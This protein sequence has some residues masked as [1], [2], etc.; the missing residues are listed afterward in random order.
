MR[1]LFA[2]AL[3]SLFA[4]H[5]SECDKSVKRLT[6]L[7]AQYDAL[8]GKPKYNADADMKIARIAL[9]IAVEKRNVNSCD[10]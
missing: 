4:C 2:L 7:Q 3:M 1:I 9:Q 10:Y 8:K 5:E 6:S